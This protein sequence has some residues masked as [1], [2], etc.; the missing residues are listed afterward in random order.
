MILRFLLGAVVIFLILVVL[1]VLGQRRLLYPLRYVNRFEPSDTATRKILFRATEGLRIEAWLLLPEKMSL[2]GLIVHAHGNGE[3][4]DQIETGFLHYGAEHGYA[5]LMPEYRGYSRSQGSPSKEL[6]LEDFEYFIGEVLRIYPELRGKMVFHG[7]SLGGG[8]VSELAKRVPP[9][10]L[11]L[12]STFTSVADVASERFFIPKAWIWD[13]YSPSILLREFKQP[14]LVIH[15]RQDDV[16]AFSH[17]ERNFRTAKDAELL[18]FDGKHSD[19]I[20][21]NLSESRSG[22]S[23][24]LKKVESKSDR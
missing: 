21:L 8:V 16:I 15:G 2:R 3:I 14:V 13:N 5:V 6:I 1:V 20:S 24:F 12:E 17:A 22:I 7:R 10:G 23:R 11:I 9:Q 19:T 4:L 18:A